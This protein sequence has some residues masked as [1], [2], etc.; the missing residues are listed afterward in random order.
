MSGRRSYFTLF[1][2]LCRGS[3]F[4]GGKI[5]A[6]PVFRYD[7]GPFSS[8]SFRRWRGSTALDNCLPH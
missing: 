6:D 3:G 5:S 2:T 7:I 4:G 1:T 8:A